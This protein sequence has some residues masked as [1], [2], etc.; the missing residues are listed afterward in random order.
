[1]HLFCIS[2]MQ[3]YKEDLC[4]RI[5]DTGCPISVGGFD[6]GWWWGWVGGSGAGSDLPAPKDVRAQDGGIGF[7]FLTSSLLSF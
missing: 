2:E 7:D 3:T 4:L 1:M 5:E 6:Q